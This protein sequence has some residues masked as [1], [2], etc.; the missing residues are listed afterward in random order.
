[1]AILAVDSFPPPDTGR[2]PRSA[3]RRPHLRAGQES[4]GEAF[5][6]GFP[7]SLSSTG[8]NMILLLDGEGTV[9]G[10]PHLPWADLSSVLTSSLFLCFC[11]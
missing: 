2:R 7:F 6:R 4:W 8:H 10:R 3:G 1:M 9:A 5:C 11:F